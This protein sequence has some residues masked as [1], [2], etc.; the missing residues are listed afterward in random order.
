MSAPSVRG[1]L[2]PVIV[3]RDMGR[4]LAF[5]RDLLGLRL[6]QETVHD[7]AVLARLGGPADAAATAAI[8]AAPDGTEIEV[9]CFARPPGKAR[10]DGGWADAGIRSVTFTVDDIDGLLRRLGDAGHAAAGEV[11]SLAVEGE[12]VR[13]AYVEGP[14]GVVLTLLERGGKK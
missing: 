10:A 7:P 8:L 6:R 13:V 4:A 1:V 14:D 2:H 11:L 5:Y 3:T 12:T 9:A